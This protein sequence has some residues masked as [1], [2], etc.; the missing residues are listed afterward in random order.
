MRVLLL[1]PPAD[2]PYLRDYYCSHSA[3]ANY[4]WH[5]YDLLVQSGF[6]SNRHEV[7]A[8]DANVLG[9]SFDAARRR[10][11]DIKPDA[12]F[13]LTGAASWRN[14]F[15]FMDSL[16]VPPSMPVVATGDLM[17]SKGAE[18]LERTSW[19]TAVLQDFTVDTVATYLDLWDPERR[20][21]HNDVELPHLQYRAGDGIHE[22]PR[23]RESTFALPLPR[24]DLFPMNRYRI[25][26][27]KNRHFWSTLTDFGCPF[28]C[29]FCVS[30]TLPY[31]TRDPDNVMRE[32]R[33]A[34]DLGYRELWVKDVTFGVNRKH[35]Q[36][37]LHLLEKE[38]LGF[39]WVALS[40]VDVVNEE[41]LARMAR[42]GCH[43]IQLGVES[44]DESILQTIEKQISPQR[45]KQI[46]A[47]C[48]R[49]RIRTL[50]HFIIGLPGETEDSARRTIEFAKELEPD[51]ASFNIATPKVGTPL[52]AEAIEKGWTDAEVDTLDNSTAFPS[53]EIG[54]LSSQRVWE[55]RNQAIREFHLR[56][57]YLIRKTLGVRSIWEL[58]R[59]IQNAMALLRSTR[60]SPKGGESL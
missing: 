14:D 20:G 15:A 10:I 39:S 24:V 46:F 59:S 32:L 4:F 7:L 56:P 29:S 41:L 23:P 16:N 5:P 37:F 13:L 22:G 31:K 12:I 42:T 27:G 8:L 25:P 36:A 47:L 3:K 60:G 28:H 43:T 34:R 11:A 19:L 44:A 21:P 49:L 9:L 35:S 40:R 26:H 53:M 18:Y 6:L 57:Q 17:L 52:R 2:Q 1:N 55:L 50:A 48:R 58:S 54:T 38:N 45:V 30:G 33:Y 51:F